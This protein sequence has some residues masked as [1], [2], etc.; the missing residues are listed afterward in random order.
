MAH[1]NVKN[2]QVA[3]PGSLGGV[4]RFPLGTILPTDASSPLPIIADWVSRIGGCDED[5]WTTSTKRDQEKKKDWNGDKVRA[6]QTGKDDTGKFK[7][8]EPKSPEAK[9]MVYGDSNV[10]VTPA[11]VSSGTKIEAHSNSDVLPH[12]AYVVETWDGDDKIRTCIN[13]AQVSEIGDI[14]F[15]SKD[16]TVYEITLDLFPDIAGDTWVE[17]TELADKLVETAFTLTIGGSPTGGDFTVSVGGQV[18][19]AIAF[20]ADGAAVQ[21]ALE[22]LPGVT[23]ATVTGASGGPFTC[24][25]TCAGAVSVS[26]DGSGLTPSGSV[27]VS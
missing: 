23:A 24:S 8:I 10:T 13:D 5:G 26:A 27:T 14:V 21:A 6:I 16:W 11:T 3:K 19:S 25:V 4:F 7:L 2:T 12:N 17:Y 15:Q 20:D 18:T 9:K 22:A 1:T